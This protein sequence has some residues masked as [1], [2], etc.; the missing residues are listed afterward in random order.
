MIH[1]YIYIYNIII[2]I[3]IYIYVCLSDYTNQV[4]G[5]QFLVNVKQKRNIRCH[6]TGVV[7]DL[8]EYKLKTV[9]LF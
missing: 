4:L 6:I 1:I 8:C 5:N 3:Y 9:Y 2:Y 7:R